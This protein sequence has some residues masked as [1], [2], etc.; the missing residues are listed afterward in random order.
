MQSGA[1]KERRPLIRLMC[2]TVLPSTTL[3]INKTNT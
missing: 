2:T 3:I 1:R